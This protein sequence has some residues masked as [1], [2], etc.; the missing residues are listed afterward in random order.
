MAYFGDMQA[1]AYSI[2]T[3]NGTLLWKAELDQHAFAMITGAPKLYAGTLYVPVSSAEELSG[4]NA[5]Y[6]CCTFRG[7]VSALNSRTGELLWKSYTIDSAAKQTSTNPAGTAMLGP[8]GAAVW[9]SPTIDPQ[10]HALY[11]GTGDNYSDPASA[12]SDAIMAFDLKSGKILWVKQLTA[13]D[14]FNWG[15]LSQ[16]KASCPKEPGGDFD[17]GAPPILRTLK[18]GTLDRRPEVG[19]C[20]RS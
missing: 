11:V 3:S 13:Q 1:R 10:R 9:S 8:S 5:K 12:T 14:R 18:D 6:P 7:S 17:I 4:A 19:C 16:D 2:D 20:L 15:C